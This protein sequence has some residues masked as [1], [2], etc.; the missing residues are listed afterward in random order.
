MDGNPKDYNSIQTAY[1]QPDTV[2]RV[3]PEPVFERDM[4]SFSSRPKMQFP[5]AQKPGMRFQ[6]C[7]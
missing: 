2:G 7:I 6:R 4:S 3:V 1:L 5:H